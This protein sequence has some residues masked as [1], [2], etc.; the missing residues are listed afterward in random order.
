MKYAE[1]YLTAADLNDIINLE[2]KDKVLYMEDELL[3]GFL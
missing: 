1:N 2:K 3:F